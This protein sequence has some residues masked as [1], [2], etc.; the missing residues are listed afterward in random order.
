L[1]TAGFYGA[2]KACSP[3][4]S[5]YNYETKEIIASNLTS[6]ASG[7]MRALIRVFNFDLSEKF[8][9][10][11]PFNLGPDSQITLTR[12]PEI[13]GLSQV[14]FLD[15]RILDSKGERV[16]HNFYCLAPRMDILDEEKANWFVTPVRQYADLTLLNS[17]GEAEIKFKS[18]TSIKE[19]ITF[20]T[21]ELENVSSNLAFLVEISVRQKLRQ[22][23]VAP[24]FLEDNYFSL[25]PKEKR[26]ITGYFFTEDL[27]G[28]EPEIIISGWNIK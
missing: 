6:R 8:R 15:L 9:T 27:E 28:D 23:T 10:E 17:L 3:L 19:D 26:T 22:K 1:P 16:D 5:I 21:L 11:L 4:H 13:E 25:L 2:K 14:Y 18:K 20:V 24:I 12:L 7:K